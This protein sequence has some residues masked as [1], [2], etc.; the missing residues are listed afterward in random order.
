MIDE[1]FANFFDCS[2]DLHQSRRQEAFATLHDLPT[3]LLVRIFYFAT[4]FRYSNLTLNEAMDILLNIC[5]VSRY[6]RAVA[7]SI[8][9]LW[10]RLINIVG[11]SKERLDQFLEWSKP[12][13]IEIFLDG[14][15][16]FRPTSLQLRAIRDRFSRAL[17]ELNRFSYFVIRRFPLTEDHYAHLSRPAPAL[18]VFSFEG[19]GPEP[20]RLPSPLFSNEAP[21]LRSL[22]LATALIDF[23]QASYPNL[24]GL[25]VRDIR[26]PF[27]PSTSTWL[28]FFIN[29]P[30]LQS[31]NLSYATSV[32]FT[33][34]YEWLPTVYLDQLQEFTLS[35]DAT[36][37]AH[38]LPKV[39]VPNDCRISLLCGF[40]NYDG[41]RL[42]QT[43]LSAFMSSRLCNDLQITLTGTSIAFSNAV[44]GQSD[45]SP[46]RH[47]PYFFFKFQWQS[48][49][50]PFDTLHLPERPFNFLSN[51][52]LQSVEKLRIVLLPINGR[53]AFDD[54]DLFCV[55]R[56][57]ISGLDS[58]KSL[59][60][61]TCVLDAVLDVI[62]D[63]DDCT[64]DEDGDHECRSVIFPSLEGIEAIETEGEELDWG[65]FISFAEWRQDIG[66]DIKYITVS[67]I[68]L[69]HL[70]WK[71]GSQIAEL[72]IEINLKY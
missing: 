60:L 55:F 22:H 69:D 67:K 19:R 61:D 12:S 35:D 43:A 4:E 7:F 57:W 66:R 42:L 34:A 11:S 2:L 68:E 44:Q 45:T 47:A 1:E 50:E 40:D 39:R 15:S 64:G 29:H 31:L 70:C 65:A 21:A 58:V 48:N 52:F 9:Q 5:R 51:A 14:G 46:L 18:E 16:D 27:P 38:L 8:P 72:D 71:D 62:S 53:Y 36:P 30:L 54:D 49:F 10:G 26:E 32:R 63:N 59:I 41:V 24:T 33:D 37:C 17:S 6:W 20:M 28:T 3:E 25:V 56:A 23:E 13:P